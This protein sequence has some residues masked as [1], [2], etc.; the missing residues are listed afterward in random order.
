M[1]YFN[2]SCSLLIA[3]TFT[4]SVVKK[5]FKVLVLNDNRQPKRCRTEVRQFPIPSGS[6]FKPFEIT[7][8]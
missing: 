7:Q 5:S 4:V 1:I 6:K 2:W 8:L 3:H